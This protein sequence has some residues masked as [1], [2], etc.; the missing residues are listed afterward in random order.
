MPNAR[1]GAASIHDPARWRAEDRVACGEHAW[2]VLAGTVNAIDGENE[3]D[4]AAAIAQELVR[5][6][7]PP[8]LAAME[9]CLLAM[10]RAVAAWAGASRPGA[11]DLWGAGLSAVLLVVDAHTARLAHVGTAR[12]YRL[13]QAGP[14]DPLVAEAL[15]IDHTLSELAR[16]R[17]DRA[18]GVLPEATVGEVVVSSLGGGR[19]DRVDFARV[20]VR[21]GTRIVL[22]SPGAHRGLET[23]LGYLRELRSPAELAQRICVEARARAGDRPHHASAIVVD[24]G[25]E[26]ASPYR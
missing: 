24:V 1:A 10:D 15:T 17:S 23:P 7:S 25:P 12:A 6:G 26:S 8:S 21:S 20:S 22:A 18:G 5:A 14:A 3:A 13:T 11:A 4:V 19:V 16:R 2:A 9:D